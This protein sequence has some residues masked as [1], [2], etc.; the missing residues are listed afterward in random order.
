MHIAGPAPR[1]LILQVWVSSKLLDDADAPGRGPHCRFCRCSVLPS[2]S[3]LFITALLRCNSHTTQATYLKCARQ[4]FLV[5]SQSCVTIVT[6]INFRTFSSSQKETSCTHQQSFPIS[7]SP[8]PR[9]P[10]S[11]FRSLGICLFW[12]FHINGIIQYLDLCDWLLLLSIVFLRF[13]HIVACISISLLFMTEYYSV[14]WI[15]HILFISSSVDGH[16]VVSVF[17]LL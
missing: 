17:S 11:Y 9:Q 3:L 13:I 12:T 16:W 6:T 2:C 14:V 15:Y 7:P 10:P 4:W 5:Y 8:S 1:L